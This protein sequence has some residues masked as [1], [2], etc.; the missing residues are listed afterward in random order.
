MMTQMTITQQAI[1]NA[2]KDYDYVR[3]HVYVGLQKAS[4]TP[5]IKRPS[6]FEGTEVY[7]YVR[8]EDDPVWR[9]ALQEPI[10]KEIGLSEQSAWASAARN[11]FAEGQTV[12]KSITEILSEVG[13]PI[14]E[15]TPIPEYVVSNPQ[16]CKGAV[17][18]L[19]REALRRFFGEKEKC[20]KI[21]VLPSSVHECIVM[22]VDNNIGT[23]EFSQMVQE[24]NAS[25]VHPSEQLADRAFV[26]SLGGNT[27]IWQLKDDEHARAFESYE[28]LK[29]NG[30]GVEKALYEQFYACDTDGDLEKVFERF[31]LDRPMDFKGHSLSVSDVVVYDGTAHYVDTIGFVDITDEWFGME[32]EV[33]A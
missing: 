19:D 6:P 15:E 1:V 31:N 32:T 20:D 2:L 27:E 33:A 29:R 8:G 13:F 23:E 3:K 9:V 14:I 5:V 28:W 25:E 18:V 24:V 21:V 17:Q 12:I 7:L 26:V 10:L 11:T 4:D 30:M 22:P 16:R